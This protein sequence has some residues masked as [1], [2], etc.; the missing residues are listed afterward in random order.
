MSPTVPRTLE[1]AIALAREFIQSQPLAARD[2]GHWLHFGYGMHLRNEWGLWGGGSPLVVELNAL[3]LHHAD[4]MSGLIITCALRDLAGEDR[5]IEA[6]VK[7]YQ[8]HWVRMT[9]VQPASQPPQEMVQA[10]RLVETLFTVCSPT[11]TLVQEMDRLGFKSGVTLMDGNGKKIAV[12]DQE[13]YEALIQ[14]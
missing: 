9:G 5:G 10:H 13:A 12:F 2:D 6:E 14:A 8:D 1:E 11:W 7:R 3:G 4:D